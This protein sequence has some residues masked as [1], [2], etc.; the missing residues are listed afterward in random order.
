MADE[1]TP[2]PAAPAEPAVPA[3]AP[4]PAPAPL[5]EQLTA[6][7]AGTPDPAA[8]PAAPAVA[9]AEPA[10]QGVRDYA[11]ANGVELPFA[12]DAAALNALLAAHRQASE[13]NYYADLGRTVAPHAQQVAAYLQQQRRQAAAPQQAPPWQPPEF[14]DKWLAMVERDENTGGLRSKQGYDPA[15]AERV[16][17][18][19]D[20]R[21]AFLKNPAAVVGPLVQEESRRVAGQMFAEQ[22]ERTVADQLVGQSAG[23]MFQ[24]DPQ[25]QPVFT[26]QGQRQLTPEGSL[27]ARSADQLWKA[28]V[29]DVRQVHALARAQVE[30]A[31]MRQRLLHAQPPAASLP[32]SAA[33]AAGSSVGGQLTRPAAAAPAA[34]QSQKG[35]SLR[36]RLMVNLDRAGAPDD[37]Q[38]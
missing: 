8:T 23:W 11:K 22:N 10:W 33:A 6:A 32:Q 19:A 20:W 13:R 21:E 18:F 12:D 25:G 37:M 35:L 24:A 16:Q 27:Y 14:D 7:S 5:A 28:G 36:E 29:R 1:L 30:N 2:A 9:Q 38:F 34:G 17:K 4:E 15:I 3:P 26:A 31:V